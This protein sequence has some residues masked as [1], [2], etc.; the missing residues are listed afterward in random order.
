MLREFSESTGQPSGDG[1]TCAPFR[2]SPSPTGD[3]TL[4]LGAFP[5]RTCP[6]LG[7]GPA[8]TVSVLGCGSSSHESFACFDR[9]MSSWKTSQVSL[10]GGSDEFSGTWPR[11]GSMRNGTVSRRRRSVRPIDGSESSCW[12][13]PAAT[14]STS[15][16]NATAGR[17]NPDS[18]HHSGTTLTDAMR[19]WAT[20]RGSDGEKGGANQRDGS[21]SLHL[22][23]MA[24]SWATLRTRDWKGGGKD[25][26][27]RQ[28]S[29]WPTP[30]TA[31][32]ERVSETLYRG[33]GNP[34][35]LGVSRQAQVTETVGEP[36]SSRAV[37]NS[38]FVE[39]LMGFPIGW[40]VFVPSATPSSRSKPPSPSDC[41]GSD[42]MRSEVLP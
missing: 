29:W 35:L 36:G 6:K 20:P 10:L 4:S 40:T 33:K 9:D 19:Q 26:L 5:A 42:C 39:A 14:D 24:V 13:T 30:Q 23:S 11:S 21:G 16:A 32:G 1:T 12:P 28:A 31:D 15:T 7:S 27:D 18:Q 2:P 22:P 34:T 38:A 8:L 41:S 3:A 25:C 17:S 37:L